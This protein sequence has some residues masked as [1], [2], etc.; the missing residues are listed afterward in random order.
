MSPAKVMIKLTM[1]HFV[2]QTRKSLLPILS[3]LNVKI[4]KSGIS[5]NAGHLI[6]IVRV[7]LHP[8]LTKRRLNA[9]KNKK[10]SCISNIR[11]WKKNLTR[12]SWG[13]KLAPIQTNAR[14]GLPQSI[15][16][17]HNA[18][19]TNVDKM[20]KNKR[21]NPTCRYPPSRPCFLTNLLGPFMRNRAKPR[22]ADRTEDMNPTRK[23]VTSVL[24]P[25]NMA[26]K[27]SISIIKVKWVCG[28]ASTKHSG[29][30]MTISYVKYK[31]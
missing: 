22:D 18:L 11:L 30:K 13:T 20:Q 27:S 28:I 1:V 17:S 14:S 4:L 24:F 31:F 16:A 9:W 2:E 23:R 21:A 6:S 12:I 3:V 8:T 26:S 19:E 10:S 29:I 15:S 7:L 5:K 25:L